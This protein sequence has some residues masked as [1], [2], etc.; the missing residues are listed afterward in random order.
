MKKDHYPSALGSIVCSILGIVCF[1][2]LIIGRMEWIDALV[3]ASLIL[4]GLAIL[5]GGYS[6]F[7]KKNKLA[8]TGLIIGVLFMAIFITLGI[9]LRNICV[10]C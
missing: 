3:V 1:L 9:M 5:T 4:F 10:V 7:V 6:L 8:G 2:L